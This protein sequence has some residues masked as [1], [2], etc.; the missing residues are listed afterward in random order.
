MSAIESNTRRAASAE[1]GFALVTTV[2]L[3][4]IMLVIGTALLSV[5][6]TQTAQTRTERVDDSAFNL[7]EAALNAE[8]F[9]LGRNWPQ[10]AAQRPV[11]GS[12]AAPC[13][14]SPGNLGQTI[15]GPLTAAA[16]SPSPTVTDQVQSILSQT[17]A[18]GGASATSR[19]WVT[20]CEEG[21]RTAWDDSLL[22]G[23][24]Y[25]PSV[26]TAPAPR[27]RRMWVRAEALVDGR[28][29]A[30]VGLVQVGQAR[31]FPSDLA[32]VTG[33]M[34]AD[35]T[36]TLGTLN[37]GQVAGPLLSSLVAPSSPNRPVIDGTVGLRCS[38][39]DQSALL[40]CLS[41]VF[42]TTS[43]LN[44]SLSGLLQSNDYVDF[45]SDT[46][47]AGD[48]LALLRQQA[49]ASGTYYPTDSA[50]QGTVAA[51]APCLPAGSAG[52]VVF[53]E[54]I[55]DGTGSCLLNTAGGAAAR[56]L[57]VGAGGV[58][59][60]GG[61]TFTGVVYALH[62]KALPGGGVC[63]VPGEPRAD[64]CIEGGSKVMGGVFVDDNASLPSAS[65]HG[66]FLV[67]PPM[68]NLNSLTGSLLC[69]PLLGPLLCNTVDGLVNTLGLNTVLGTV[70]PQLN[71]SLPAVTYDA[72]T[73][74]AVT[75]FGDSALVS[76]TFRQVPP[77]F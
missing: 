3:V 23:L 32:V 35:L 49:Q 67:V 66:R 36:S 18:G 34:G 76:G 16:A 37:G 21:G 15:T 54:Q 44:P 56:T 62:R 13:G 59:V 48:Q 52:K 4:A 14:G 58:R 22:D 17:Y 46:A 10:S 72:T 53:I 7:A 68:V 24:S 74:G 69:N 38:L 19:W 39:L 42:K 77:R 30:V 47:I 20:A 61:G 25:D 70:L 12:P 8:A 65:R 51:G 6:L 26:A 45:R 40:G 50:G 2:A 5:V 73:V 55:G 1:D 43:G 64:V 29:R 27:P 60:Q 31:V 33:Q 9:L 28:R 75:A 41:G 71:P 63:S 57:V 11:P